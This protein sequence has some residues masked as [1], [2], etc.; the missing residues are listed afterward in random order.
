MYKL[1]GGRGVGVSKVAGRE[2]RPL[3]A[4]ECTSVTDR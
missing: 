1:H 4:T 2:F 3:R